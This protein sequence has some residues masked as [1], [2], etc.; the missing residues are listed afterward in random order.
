MPRLIL[1]RHAESQWNRQGRF[2]GWGDPPLTGDGARQALDRGR[3]LAAE[4]G[5]PGA[6]Y[7]SVL[8]RAR[9]TLEL[10]LWAAKAAPA[11]TEASWRLNER[12]CGRWEGMLK[13]EADAPA[14]WAWRNQALA[15]PP[16]LERGDPRHPRHDPRYRDIPDDLLPGGESMA[17]L[18]RRVEPLWRTRIIPSLR[19]WA[20]V[21]VVAHDGSLRSLA[22]MAL[23]TDELATSCGALAPAHALRLELT[24]DLRFK[25][26]D[27]LI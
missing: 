2:S 10:A 27:Q 6:V 3:R 13:P 9:Q 12:H 22:A 20:C 1:L 11:E 23:A 4:A 26:M 14:L 18:R 8:I 25:A 7:C 24:P 16:P 15:L 17:D 21:W 19:R 5:R